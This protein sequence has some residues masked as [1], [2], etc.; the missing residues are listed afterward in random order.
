MH[1]DFFKRQ[2]KKQS[3]QPLKQQIR[4]IPCYKN[5]VAKSFDR[6]AVTYDRFAEF[7][8]RVLS[9]LIELCPSMQ[10]STCLDLGCGTG[11][12]LPFLNA[13]SNRVVALDISSKMLTQATSKYTNTSFVCADAETLPFAA[14]SFD[15]V[16][17]N[18]AIQ[19]SKN[20]SSLTQEVSHT[21]S[22]GGY[23]LAS[24]LCQNSMIEI[25]QCWHQVDGLDHTNT[26]LTYD[27]VLCE[28][29]SAN[30]TLESSHCKPVIMWFDTPQ[31][32]IDSI[33]RVGASVLV[34]DKDRRLVTPST[35]ARFLV[36]YEKLRT[37]KG[38]PLTYQVVY[39]LLKK[40]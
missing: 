29:L 19:W 30:M 39:F 2:S 31:A 4:K 27:E 38:I 34:N 25:A 11:N 14:E 35:W 32:A 12:G 37:P 21:L 20:L 23:F 13:L 22:S 7:Q 36:E 33:K 9:E 24:S 6:A 17:S 18:L 40:K 15:L 5:V 28:V 8:K 3:N 10:A 1:T 26:Y 16:L